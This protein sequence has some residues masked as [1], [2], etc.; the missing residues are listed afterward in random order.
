M[1]M[2]WPARRLSRYWYWRALNRVRFAPPSACVVLIVLSGLLN[3]C[4]AGGVA[5]EDEGNRDPF[6]PINRVV[7]AANDGIDRVLLGPIAKVY[8]YLPLPVRSGVSSFFSNLGEPKVIVNQ[9]LQG[10]PRL[11]VQDALRF[12][13]NSTLGLG[14]LIDIAAP[15]G[16][17]EHN[18]DFS[19]T[20]TL[21]GVG[22][23]PYIVFPLLGPGTLLGLPGRI[24]D[25][26]TNA[27]RYVCA[28]A[29]CMI[30]LSAVQAVNLRASL[31][32]VIKL[33]REAIDPYLFTREAYRQ[34]RRF[35]RYDGQP[36]ADD[37]FDEA[38][39]DGDE[40]DALEH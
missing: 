34:Q 36:P 15:M 5:H 8:L 27:S 13:I 2:L 18:E 23:G 20:L 4:A 21:W 30:P 32:G 16:L 25:W 22:E 14:G 39:F 3:G 9:L 7:Y 28:G 33:Q 12:T 26:F 35:L 40:D 24:V 10:K 38:E 17:A 37:D 11:A 19:Q 6:E 29:S 1:R 31:E